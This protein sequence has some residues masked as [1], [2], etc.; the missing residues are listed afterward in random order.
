M[1][2]RHVIVTGA[3]N[4]IGAAIVRKCVEAG[5]HVIGCDIDQPGLERLAASLPPG[6]FMH[7]EVDVGD[8]AALREF[9]RLALEKSP[10]VYGLVNNAGIYHGKSVYK[11]S[12]DEIDRILDVNVKALLYLSK[13][14]AATLTQSGKNGVIVNVSS[15]AGEVGSSD[16]LYGLTKAAVIGLTKSNAMNF[17]PHVRVNAVSPALIR[18][19]AILHKIPKYRLEEYERQE[20]LKDPILPD[21]VADVVTFLLSSASR[22]LTGKIVPVDNGAYPR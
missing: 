22:H 1:S 20:T 17:A 14:F 4:G 16:A 11:Y 21:G 15:V 9:Y 5:Y 6:V 13:D 18:E 12:D 10:E 3:A 19:T 8:I 2:Q 7:F